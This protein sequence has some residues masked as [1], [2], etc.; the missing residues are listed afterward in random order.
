MSAN[1]RSIIRLLKMGPWT[2]K[3]IEMRC[4]LGERA[5]GNCMRILEEAG[6]AERSC[7]DRKVWQLSRVYLKG[8]NPSKD[9]PRSGSRRRRI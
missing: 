5:R 7:A 2:S 6:I 1:L 4:F 9:A 3:E 8:F